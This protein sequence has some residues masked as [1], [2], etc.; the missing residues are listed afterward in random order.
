MRWKGLIFIIIL[1]VGILLLGSFFTDDWLEGKIENR[2]TKINGA[3]V[4]IDELDL[5]LIELKLGWNRMQ[6][7]DSKNTLRNVVETGKCEVNLALVPLFYRDVVINKFQISGFQTNTKRT[8]DGKIE[9]KRKVEKDK[10]RKKDQKPG[11]I[12]KTSKK[13]QNRVKNYGELRVQ[14]AR[15]QI[16]TDSLLSAINL[17]SIDYIDSVEKVYSKKYNYWKNELNSKKIQED[18]EKLEKDYN[19]IRKIDPESIKT[20]KEI[21]KSL[22]VIRKSR[23][24]LIEVRDRFDKIRDNLRSDIEGV[25]V[26]SSELN[27]I[28]QQDY[29]RIKKMAKIPDLSRQNIANMIFGEEVV[30]RLN[31]YLGIINKIRDYHQ[32]LSKLKKEKEKKQKPE[33]FEGQD[34]QYSG[35]YN[36]PKFWVKKIELSG[37]TAEGIELSGQIKNIVSNQKLINKT[38]DIELKGKRRDGTS[39]LISAV[40]DKRSPSADDIFRLNINNLSLNNTV[41]SQSKIFPYKISKG[42]GKLK[43]KLALARG[44]FEG[45]AKF[46][47]RELQFAR[48]PNKGYN[49]RISSIIEKIVSDLDKLNMQVD[50]AGSQEN[51]DLSLSSNLDDV[52]N[53]K[54]KSIVQEEIASARNEIENRIDS[55]VSSERQKVDE[56]LRTKTD[57]LKNEVKR[58]EKK[59]KKYEEKY[60]EKKSDLEARIKD[61]GK[62][63]LDKM[64]KKGKDALDD[65]F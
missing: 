22:Q 4:E 44:Q 62:D 37:E 49:N 2:A 52:F 21:K 3:K 7:T 35:Q 41:I 26:A 17:Q 57:E 46:D 19:K 5:S 56:E 39:L 23:K 38:T 43:G 28:V 58:Y 16:N 24:D 50:I 48:L 6:I 45:R 11:L 40:L 60:E 36:F 8:T 14:N 25:K 42:V 12:T 15:N 54:V 1:V 31:K 51:T 53:K 20:V 10:K 32:K 13:L 30:N 47:S 33:R 61:L 65:L 34:I 18:L 59:I 64:K 27:N 55:K 29:N 63:E 9:K